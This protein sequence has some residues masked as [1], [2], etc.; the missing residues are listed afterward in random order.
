M[1][2]CSCQQLSL[3]VLELVHDVFLRKCAS[4]IVLIACDPTLTTSVKAVQSVYTSLLTLSQK[5]PSHES[6][7]TQ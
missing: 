1:C 6:S 7:Y 2:P 3:A 4:D 5:H